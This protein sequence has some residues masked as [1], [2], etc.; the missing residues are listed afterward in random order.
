M[1]KVKKKPTTLIIVATLGR[2]TRLLSVRGFAIIDSFK[3]ISGLKAMLINLIDLK[4]D[5]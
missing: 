3:M 1:P 4:S 5:Y 2:R